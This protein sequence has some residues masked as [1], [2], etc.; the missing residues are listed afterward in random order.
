M[1]NNPAIN[2]AKQFEKEAAG[3][4]DVPELVDSASEEKKVEEVSDEQVDES[5]LEAK[6]IEL[7]VSQANVSRAKAV[8]ALRNNK[9]DIVNAI[10]ELTM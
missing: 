8:K 10:M 2:A 1:S 4:E 9:G 3:N 7:V 6:D 5:G